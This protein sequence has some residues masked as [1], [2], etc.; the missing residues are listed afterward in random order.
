MRFGWP[1]AALLIVK[2]AFIAHPSRRFKFI[3]H[4]PV[5]RIFHTL[6]DHLWFASCCFLCEFSVYIV[7]AEFIDYTKNLQNFFSLLNRIR[8]G[9]QLSWKFFFYNVWRFCFLGCFVSRYC[10][11]VIY[12]WLLGSIFNLFCFYILFLVFH[13][14]FFFEF[15]FGAWGSYK[16]HKARVIWISLFFGLTRTKL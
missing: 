16:E 5:P 6:C 2:P 3:R 7:Y 8:M 13:F 9:S 4:S 12:I 14:D 1:I 11:Y 10:L 15:E